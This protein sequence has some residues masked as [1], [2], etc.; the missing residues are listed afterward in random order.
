VVRLCLLVCVITGSSSEV[1]FRGLLFEVLM[2]FL[3]LVLT[4]CYRRRSFAG[5]FTSS[6]SEYGVFISLFLFL[7]FVTGAPPS[8]WSGYGGSVTS[9]VLFVM[10]KV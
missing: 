1:L 4:F 3:C 8:R 5:D 7:W 6:L 9:L 2:D 10:G